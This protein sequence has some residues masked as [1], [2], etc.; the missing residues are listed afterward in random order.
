MVF[1]PKKAPWLEAFD[2]ELIAFP[3]GKHDD[4]VDALSQ[5][6]R[7]LDYR[8]IEILPLKLYH[9]KRWLWAKSKEEKSGLT[10]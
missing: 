7:A 9:S 5:F 10:N 8:P 4:Q 1:L 3:N 6:L 2:Y